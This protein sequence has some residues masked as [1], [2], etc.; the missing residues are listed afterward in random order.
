MSCTARIRSRS[1]LA[2]G[3]R[4]RADLIGEDP[5]HRSRG[6][7]RGFEPR[8]AACAARRL[9]AAARR[10]DRHRDRQSLR[11]HAHGDGGRRVGARPH[12]AIDGRSAHPQRDPDRRGDEPR[13]LGR[14]A[15]RQPRARDRRQHRD[16]SC[17]AGHLLRD[18]NRFGEMGRHA[19]VRARQGAPRA[20][21]AGRLDGRAAAPR[22]TFSR[23]RAAQC[24]ARARGA[25]GFARAARRARRGRHDRR[26]RRHRGHDGRR[27]AATAR[28][29]A[30]RQGLRARACCAARRWC[31]CTSS[32]ARHRRHPDPPEPRML[33]RFSARRSRR[34]MPSR[35]RVRANARRACR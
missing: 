10:A 35:P 18:R 6:A 2:D 3:V 15:A 20:S 34:E 26:H 27:P 25:T 13:Q 24:R 23:G 32:R 9:V 7:A 16:H 1:L 33:R 8:V 30:H 19:I 28:R 14:P 5:G 31:T 21:G 12:V 22:R 4:T 17:C 29:L 11:L